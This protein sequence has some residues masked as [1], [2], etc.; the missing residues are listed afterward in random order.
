ML[1]RLLVVTLIAAS[2]CGGA[3]G[4]VAKAQ[5]LPPPPCPA[6]S[7]GS[8][9][10]TPP[11]APQLVSRL[12]AGI[13]LTELASSRADRLPSAPARLQLARLTLEPRAGSV[14]RQAA[15]PILFYVVAG[16]VTLYVGGQPTIL[17]AGTSALVHLDNLY[18]LVNDGEQ[19][20]TLLR[21]AVA[22]MD[23][24]D[25]PVAVVI[26]PPPRL[27]T[28]VA[29]PPT[30]SLLFRASITGHPSTSGRLFVACLVWD[31]PGGD[32]GN[33]RH[34]GPVGLRVLQGT[35]TVDAK[36]QIPETGC[37]L[38]QANLTHRFQGADP[39][40]VALLFGVIPEGQDLWQPPDPLAAPGA[41]APPDLTCGAASQ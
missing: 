16:R 39:A 28:P 15:G 40:P 22:P 9:S 11:P 7:V 18:A 30:S 26:T 27:Q 8:T 4:P 1:A 2:L 29:G 20:A 21:L 5:E 35:V 32:S 33:F 12:P 6:A 25:V 37:T 3:A 19:P 14:T 38:L 24:P 10:A 31:A 34:P 23:A 36:W 17:A 13:A 41:A